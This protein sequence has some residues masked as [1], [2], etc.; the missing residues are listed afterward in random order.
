MVASSSVAPV[1]TVA[2]LLPN[3]QAIHA[4]STLDIDFLYREIFEQEIYMQ[5]GIEVAEGSV[6][7]DCGANI[8]MFSIYAAEAAGP[9]VGISSPF[10]TIH[11]VTGC[12]CDCKTAWNMKSAWQ[13]LALVLPKT[14]QW[15][16]M[17]DMCGN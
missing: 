1:C 17:V 15:Y 11:H 13:N 5:H 16:M 6:V 7:M 3:G 2:R 12:R 10:P 4:V 9:S 14:V 8:G